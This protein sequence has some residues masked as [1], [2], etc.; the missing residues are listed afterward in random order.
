ML[1]LVVSLEI[2]LLGVGLLA[3][4]NDITLMAPSLAAA[5]LRVLDKCAAIYYYTAEI[6]LKFNVKRLNVSSIH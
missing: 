3:Y 2:D 6:S 4:A 1:I 5:M